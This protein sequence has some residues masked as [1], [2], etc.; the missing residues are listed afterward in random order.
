MVRMRQPKPSPATNSQVSPAGAENRA[1]VIADL[2]RRKFLEVSA[3]D[4]A[5]SQMRFVGFETSRVS[6]FRRLL[7]WLSLVTV[8]AAQTGLDWLAGRD[9]PDRR[10]ARLRLAFERRGGVFVKL[11]MHLAGR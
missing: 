5:L 6:A 11:G 10:T 7:S 4:A 3:A 8:F 2:P 9:T 1:G